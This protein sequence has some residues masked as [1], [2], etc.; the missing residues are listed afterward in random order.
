V[1]CGDGGVFCVFLWKWINFF[2]LFFF[3]SFFFSSNK[4]KTD[5]FKNEQEQHL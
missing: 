5:F 3:F 4:S 2:L 1:V